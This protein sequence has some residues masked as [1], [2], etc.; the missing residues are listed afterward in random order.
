VRRRTGA[1]RV[2][3][4]EPAFVRP[5]IALPIERNE[6]W[7]GRRYVAATADARGA[8]EPARMAP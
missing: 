3:P 6:Q 5:A 8:D 7:L 4:D 1:I 2:L